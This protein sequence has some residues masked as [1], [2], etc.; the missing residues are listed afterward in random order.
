VDSNPHEA[1]HYATNLTCRWTLVRESRVVEFVV[2]VCGL[3]G[4][5]NSLPSEVEL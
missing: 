4:V 5:T 2:A 3:L 1:K